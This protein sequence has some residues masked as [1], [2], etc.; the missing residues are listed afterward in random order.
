M[1]KRFLATLL[2]ISMLCGII[3]ATT[4][5][6]DMPGTAIG[7]VQVF[8]TD[9]YEIKREIING[10]GAFPWGV[11]RVV[12]VTI[13][14]TGDKPIE[15]WLLAYDTFGGTLN[16][17]WGS[18]IIET[19]ACGLV[20]IKNHGWNGD[21]E[22]GASVSF[23]YP[24][25]NPTGAPGKMVLVQDRV[26]V[27][28]HDFDVSLQID[29][30]FGET[31]IGSI[32]VENL[33][34]K[35]FEFWEL[36]I[37]ANFTINNING[38][39]WSA[40]T[41]SLDNGLQKIKGT[42]L[43]NT[44]VIEADSSL[45]IGFSGTK[46]DIP[47]IFDVNL[48]EVV[49]DRDA[50]FWTVF[51]GETLSNNE[52]LYSINPT[53]N[54]VTI[55]GFA[56]ENYN[57][58]L[59]I[60]THISGLP[61]RWIGNGAF[62]GTSITSVE[63]HNEIL[64]IGM[65]A[66]EKCNELTEIVI[67][68]SVEEIHHAAFYGC[69]SL[70]SV[71]LGENLYFIGIA[72]F[73]DCISLSEIV[74]PDNV[75]S[76]W[77]YSF[78]RTGLTSVTIGE[79]VRRIPEMAFADCPW[80]DPET[81]VLLGNNTRV[82]DSAFQGSGSGIPFPSAYM[83]SE[84]T[85][86]EDCKRESCECVVIFDMQNVSPA[87]WNVLAT[88]NSNPVPFLRRTGGPSTALTVNS[89]SNERITVSVTGR[90]GTSHGLQILV[91]NIPTQENHE[92]K[93]IYSG[94]FPN[95]PTATARIRVENHGGTLSS[96]EAELA[97][98]EAVDGAFTITLTKTSEEIRAHALYTTDTTTAD[99]RFRYSLGCNT[100]GI[101]EENPGPDITYTDIKIIEIP[102]Q[103]CVCGDCEECGWV[104][105]TTPPVTTEPPI[106]TTEVITTV[107]V[108]TTTPPTT[109]TVEI[110]T[111]T[112]PTTVAPPVIV[113]QTLLSGRVGVPYNATLTA[114]GEGEITWELVNIQNLVLPDG[115]TLSPNGTISGTP[116]ES[117]RFEFFARV[118]N[119]VTTTTLITIVIAEPEVTTTTTAETTT[120]PTTTTTEITTTPPVTT[121]PEV[122][123]PILPT[124]CIV[125]FE[126]N[127]EIG[128]KYELTVKVEVRRESYSRIIFETNYDIKTF[129]VVFRVMWGTD[130][131]MHTM[132]LVGDVRDYGP[133]AGLFTRETNVG[134]VTF[135]FGLYNKVIAAGTPIA[136]IRFFPNWDEIGENFDWNSLSISFECESLF[137]YPTIS[138]IVY[139]CAS[140]QNHPNDCTCCRHCGKD[141]C[142]HRLGDVNGDGQITI[143]DVL[144]VLLFLARITNPIDKC[145]C[146][147][148][149][150]L[151]KDCLNP[152]VHDV[153]AL[154][155]SLIL[156]S[157]RESGVPT[158]EDVLDML[159]YL[160]KL[161]NDQPRHIL[162][163][164]WG[165][166]E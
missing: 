101:D 65:F 151:L 69:T 142:G 150:V 130:V 34:A 133:N 3:S 19:T 116:T 10:W 152:V 139:T 40:P 164:N 128:C 135:G 43:T 54:A 56:N 109:T 141:P 52:W 107:E 30:D 12:E 105:T 66:F 96:N 28:E 102:P 137:G 84:E 29:H 15:N 4:A 149:C 120:P 165:I 31:F 118:N 5:S 87:D 70:E 37:N 24:L 106:T 1:K 113:P 136:Y 94:I 64:I 67:P 47:E 9:N 16:T 114:T 21:I 26:S 119:I 86:C 104:V 22:P 99:G 46:T 82:S 35:P 7:F 18:A 78:Y 23:T 92:Y 154:C 79:G 97:T 158:I 108:T 44:H 155:A 144:D 110:T 61:V 88:E 91:G 81:V 132:R 77:G 156:D 39:S 160:A 57:P 73:A 146:E 159:L 27:N 62:R 85:A 145:G 32:T 13:T 153:N 163:I 63:F 20:Y 125:C 51:S 100:R 157:S 11:T 123:T 121:T 53:S 58:N 89:V 80:L 45:V 50:L 38:N 25:E 76:L 6:A 134:T 60:P 55:R 138:R 127:C 98:A 90:S 117:G 8:T 72:A 49:L 161:L 95:N 131:T 71:T 83:P 68:D 166:K 48:T 115:L 74:I 111:T 162:I 148:E 126:L 36:S 59:V 17:I 103:P 122:T 42:R 93:I 129:P 2:T 147:F 112:P 143:T 41:L 14:N 33:T 75:T 140:C 124:I